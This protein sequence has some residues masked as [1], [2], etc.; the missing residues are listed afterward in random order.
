MAP[1][2]ITSVASD[3]FLVQS[4]VVPSGY[5]LSRT[6]VSF[7]MNV[8]IEPFVPGVLVPLDSRSVLPVKVTAPLVMVL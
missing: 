4:A 8:P 5:V 3:L 7:V 6:L 1:V 2:G